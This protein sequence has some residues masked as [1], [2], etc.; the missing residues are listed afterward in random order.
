[1]AT[2]GKFKRATSRGEE[3]QQ[4]ERDYHHLSI[5]IST[6]KSID[7]KLLKIDL[8]YIKFLLTETLDKKLKHK[9]NECGLEVNC[10][11]FQKKV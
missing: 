10:L 11:S 8:E 3:S 4:L 2:Q 7:S 1:V 6:S 9:K 5:W